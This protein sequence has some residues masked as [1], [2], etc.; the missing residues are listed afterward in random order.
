M[1]PFA[2]IQLPSRYYLDHFEEMLDFVTARYAH[3]I[4]PR[5][6]NFLATFSSLSLNARCLYVRFMNRKGRAFYREHLA[7]EEITSLADAIAE[8]I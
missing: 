4:G 3:A 1:A 7:Y 8:L 2:S 5:E 6:R